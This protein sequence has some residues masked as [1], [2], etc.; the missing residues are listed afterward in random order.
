MATRPD[1]YV[2]ALEQLTEERPLPVWIKKT[3][4]GTATTL[5]L[6]WAYWVSA[7]LTASPTEADVSAALRGATDRIDTELRHSRELEHRI[8]EALENNTAS[9]NALRVEIAELRTT[10]KHRD[11]R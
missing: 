7:G 11:G 2:R 3:I 10:I 8:T 5:F 9:I 4:A 6:G 1:A